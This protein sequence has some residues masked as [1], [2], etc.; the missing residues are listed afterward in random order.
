[1]FKI[2]VLED[3]K[4][5]RNLMVE[6]LNMSGF[7]VVAVENGV[8]GIEAFSKENFDMIITDVMMDEMDGNEFAEYVRSKDKNIHIIMTTALGEFKSK[9]KGYL[10]GVDDYIVKPINYD[11]LVLKVKSILR[12]CKSNELNIFSFSDFKMEEKNNDILVCGQLISLRKKEYELL[13]K[14]LSNPNKL[15]TRE[16]LIEEFWSDDIDVSDRVIDTQI[17]RIRNKTK[18]SSFEIV[19]VRGIGYKVI[20][21]E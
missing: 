6:F 12:R 19:T 3:D 16:E 18:C 1:M 9:E 10:N 15:F 20:I 8:Q 13:H 2:L 5:A 7:D 17:K 14:M 11:E 4:N 21:N